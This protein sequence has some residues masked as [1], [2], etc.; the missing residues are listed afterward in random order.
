MGKVALL[1]AT[2]RQAVLYVPLMFLMDYLLGAT[3]LVLTQVLAEILALCVSLVVF[4][5]INPD[6]GL[7]KPAA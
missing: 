1:L 2:I 5:K 4:S 3:G 6:R 7:E